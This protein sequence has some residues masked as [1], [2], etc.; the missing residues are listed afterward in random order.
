MTLYETL[1][2]NAKKYSE[3]TALSYFGNK[4][5]YAELFEL[6]EGFASSL[7]NL[8]I[9]RKDSVAVLLP[10]TPELMVSIYAS[11][12]IGARV[13]LLNPKSPAEELVKELSMTKAKVLIFSTIAKKNVY[14]AIKS[15]ERLSSLKLIYADILKGLPAMFKVFCLKKLLPPGEIR[16]IKKIKGNADCISFS[17]SVGDVPVCDDDKEEAVV[18]FSGGTSGEIKAIVH[19]SEALNNS[20]RSCAYVVKDY[21]AN[22]RILAILPAFHIFGL[23]VAIHFPIYSGGECIL[24]PFFH[25]GTIAKIVAS[26]C[27]H[28]LPG[29]PTIFSRICESKAI[30][31]YE[32]KRKINVENFIWAICG[33]DYLTRELRVKFNDFI[34]R[35]G[36]NGYISMGYG[37]SECCP[38]A[39][40]G[41]K[42][43]E[44]GCVGNIFNG[45]K[46]SIHDKDT[47]ALLK[48]GESGEIY[49]HSDYLMKKYFCEDGNELVPME[50]EN[51][52]YI[53]TGDIG[54]MYGDRLFYEYRMRRI[55][56]VSGN[57]IFAGSIEKV[58]ESMD[59][60]KECHV[61]GVKHKSRGYSSF[62]Y[63]VLKNDCSEDKACEEI[64][65][66]CRKELI[67][68]AIPVELCFVNGEDVDRT[69]LGKIAYGILEKKAEKYMNDKV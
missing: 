28:I 11:N 23:T 55:I 20:A 65:K 17:Q 35:N 26:D 42:D 36:G 67:P 57:T 60:V 9:R 22:L 12:K 33:G 19:T 39:V 5:K 62:A 59:M 30:A 50:D 63:V 53:K 29:V 21:R 52:M 64:M 24:V 54:H 43:D 66:I 18:I 56:K 14:D 58:I 31:R 13:V 49:L 2:V 41:P 16:K 61:V 4:I 47:G 45:C 8:G 25:M 15:D 38:M 27:P 48:D 44:E 34:R 69:A 10:N 68:Y 1:A 32:K 37:M 46:I 3:F 7:Y 40:S 6:T 51:G